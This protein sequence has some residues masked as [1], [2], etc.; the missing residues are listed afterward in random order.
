MKTSNFDYELPPELIA[1]E[2][3]CERDQS[4]MLVLHRREERWEHRRFADIV[5]YLR[6]GDLLVVNDTRVIP[7][8][9]FGRKAATGGKVEILLL[10]E[11]APATWDILLHAARRP[12]VGSTV[13]F[14]DG[15]ASAILLADGE[16]GRA[17]IRVESAKPWLD[18]VAEIG[19]PPLPPY[20]KRP[21]VAD[22]KSDTERY[23]TVYAKFPGAV[24]APTAGLHFTDAVFQA[25]EKKGVRRA[26][27]TLH[28]GLGTFRPVDAENVD[29]HRMEAERY[30]VPEETA[31]AIRDCR[32]RGG[33]VVA[34]GSTSVRTLETVAAEHGEVVACSGRSSL[35]IRP[36]Y[37]FK[38]VDAMLTNFHL[39][40]ST[41]VMM[42]S[43]LATRELILKAYA[44]A[45]RERYRFFSY[46]DCMLI[47]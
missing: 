36:P 8:R 14:G 6:D 13:L 10:E 24:A 44:E 39:P 31:A 26:A 28:V 25:L 15:L 34:V 18:V 3:S 16:K 43:A 7:A 35:F 9:V 40:R 27:V 1:Q 5:E 37:E 12:K 4:R 42:V 17:S 30:V 2:P 45:V 21:D 38:V 33:R 22:W 32:A 29:D 19:E 20:I 46:G 11:T 41:L 23:Q 47:L